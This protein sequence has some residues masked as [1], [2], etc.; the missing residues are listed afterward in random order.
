MKFV[1]DLKS[2]EMVGYLQGP[3]IVISNVDSTDSRHSII[4]RPE[5]GYF[6]VFTG[7]VVH[8]MWVADEIANAIAID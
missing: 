7:K 4:S 5:K 6:T 8:S 3:R 1:P 2:S